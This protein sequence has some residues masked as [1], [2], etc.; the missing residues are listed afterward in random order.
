MC[1]HPTLLAKLVSEAGHQST[2]SVT[3]RLCYNVIRW[4]KRIPAFTCSWLHTFSMRIHVFMASSFDAFTLSHCHASRALSD[5]SCALSKFEVLSLLLFSQIKSYFCSDHNNQ[6]CLARCHPNL[7][8]SMSM[9]VEKGDPACM[10]GSARCT[11]APGWFRCLFRE[12]KESLMISNDV[13]EQQD[14]EWEAW[15]EEEIR[16][17]K[18]L[19]IS[20]QGPKIRSLLEERELGDPIT[21][22]EPE[23][24]PRQSLLYQAVKG[25]ECVSDTSTGLVK[26]WTRVLGSK[27]SN[28]KCRSLV[29][30]VFLVRS[31]LLVRS[32][33]V[34]GGE[35]P[36]KITV[37]SNQKTLNCNNV[38][39]L[40]DGQAFAALGGCTRYR[41]RMY[42]GDAPPSGEER[43]DNLG[44]GW[45]DCA[46]V[47]FAVRTTCMLQGINMERLFAA[48]GQYIYLGVLLVPVPEADRGLSD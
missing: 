38:M 9:S 19:I 30:D 10:P 1:R 48:G 44:A 39:L 29:K 25:G 6:T 5:Q 18:R 45:Y 15:Q 2:F 26:A 41:V 47:D 28:K 37:N 7:D 27:A 8:Y 40:L 23:P 11:R 22:E 17:K 32:E 21:I 14:L 36:V 4:K 42:A 33:G 46:I 16:H 20:E 31:E 35:M 43:P 34:I 13:L 12:F 3:D 24:E